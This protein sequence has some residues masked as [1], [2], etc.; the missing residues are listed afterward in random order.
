[1]SAVLTGTIDFY[2]FIQLSLTLTLPGAYKGQRKAKPIGFISSH[3]FHL[4][5]T[6]LDVVMG[7]FN[8]NAL[9]LLF[10]KS[11]SET[12]GITSVLPTASTFLTLA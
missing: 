4:I 3:N 7:Q 11:W 12:R 5:R 6:K 9:R 8:L 10:S 1:M 2:N